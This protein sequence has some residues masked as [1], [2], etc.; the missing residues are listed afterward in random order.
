MAVFI[1]RISVRDH[2]LLYP[3]NLGIAI[4]GIASSVKHNGCGRLAAPVVDF[5]VRAFDYVAGLPAFSTSAATAGTA[6]TATT[7]TVSTAA[8]T[9]SLVSGLVD[10]DWPTVKLSAVHF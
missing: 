5:A 1:F 7:A 9:R 6:A 3:G 4:V 2:S 10:N 8:V